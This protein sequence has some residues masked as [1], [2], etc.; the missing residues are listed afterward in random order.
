MELTG[1]CKEDFEKWYYSLYSFEY[2]SDFD[3]EINLGLNFEQLPL[4]MQC[5]VYV[6]WFDS[7]KIYIDDSF[8]G[9][10]N[11]FYSCTVHE[12]KVSVLNK[13]KTRQEARTK[14]L[15]KANEIY[16]KNK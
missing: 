6:D 5:G 16:N 10:N 11:E 12:N 1:K 4:S 7:C 8:D 9:L 2:I 14:A 15:E 3:G 13:T